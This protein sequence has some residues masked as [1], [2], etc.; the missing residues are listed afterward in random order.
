L[1]AL[2]QRVEHSLRVTDV[3]HQVVD[4]H[5]VDVAIESPGRIV[6]AHEQILT[7]GQGGMHDRVS[8]R[9]RS[10]RSGVCGRVSHGQQHEVAA[11]DLVVARERLAAVAV[12]REVWAKSHRIISFDELYVVRSTA[13]CQQ[14]H[15]RHRLRGVAV[16]SR[17]L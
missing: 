17:G 1:S 2:G 8:G 15:V 6:R 4:A 12:E 10:R 11:E 7:D 9:T 16:V 14:G 3:R 5:A 13:S